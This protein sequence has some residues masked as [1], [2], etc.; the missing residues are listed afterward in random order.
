MTEVS[1]FDIKVHPLHRSEFLSIIKSSLEKGHQLAQFGINS[2]IVNQIVRNKE[3]KRAIN[4]ADLVNIDGMSVVW[5][6]RFLGYNVPERVATPDLADEIL[7]MAEREK[8]RIFLLGAKETILTQCI[9]SLHS[10]L[11]GLEIAGCRNGYFQAEEERLVVDMINE[12]QPDILLIGMSSPKK[13]FFCEK[14]R[15]ELNTNYILGVGGYFDILAGYT[16]RAPKWMQNIG[17]EWFFRFI[18]EPR[19]M[20]KRYLIGIFEFFWLV[21]KEKF[22]KK[23]I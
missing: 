1:F 19:R 23:R 11:P 10:I 2:D 8:F 22:N 5:A 9:S 21:F 4:N 3:Y 20:W 17:M 16:K 6:L 15:G 18:Q 7:A 12:A 13:E 14:Y